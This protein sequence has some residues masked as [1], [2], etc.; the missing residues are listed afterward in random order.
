MIFHNHR[1]KSNYIITSHRSLLIWCL[2]C[3]QCL[4]APFLPLHSCI[5]TLNGSKNLY[6]LWWCHVFTFMSPCPWLLPGQKDNSYFHN[7]LSPAP[8][9]RVGCPYQPCHGTCCII[10][11]ID[12]SH[13]VY[14]VGVH[15]QSW[16]FPQVSNWQRKLRFSQGLQNLHTLVTCYITELVTPALLPSPYS[17]WPS[18]SSPTF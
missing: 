16:D 6:S 15:L 5:A 14:E 9:D 11:E 13:A 3:H 7:K 4:T 12:E 1:I 8:P 18:H 2:L 10:F 17:H